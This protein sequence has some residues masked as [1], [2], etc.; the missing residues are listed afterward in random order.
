MSLTPDVLWAQ[1][2]D[3][4]YLTIDLKDVQEIKV[5]LERESL[6]FSGRVGTSLYEFSLEFHAPIKREESKWSTRRLVEFCL[7]KEASESW[8]RLS[9]SKLPWVKVD[10]AKW[11][12]SDD[13][14]E[15]KGAFDVDGMGDMS[16]GTGDGRGPNDFDSDDD[17]EILKDLPPPLHLQ[18]YGE[19]EETP[20]PAAASAPVKEA[21]QELN[22]ID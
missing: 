15:G 16:F 11:Q 4:V 2:P 5:T 13:E 17:E 18:E 1:R 12:D 21:G 19:E 3:S 8:P 9:K 14:G 10:W 20:A 7:M 22:E 6:T